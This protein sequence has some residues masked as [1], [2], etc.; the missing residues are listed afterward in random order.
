MSELATRTQL[1]LK[2][3]V[4]HL[5]DVNKREEVHLRDKIV[6][7]D[8][9]LMKIFP[10]AKIEKEL[11]VEGTFCDYVLQIPTKD[12]KQVF[13][14][15]PLTKEQ[16]QLE[17]QQLLLE[18]Q[19]PPHYCSVTQE[20][21]LKTLFKLKLW[22]DLGHRTGFLTAAELAATAR[23]G[24]DTTAKIRTLLQTRA[25]WSWTKGPHAYRLDV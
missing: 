21:D 9:E 18:I 4:E 13:S 22:Q 10:G 14:T 6:I 1:T 8:E 25:G 16:E 24:V 15:V 19:G 3:N 5:T 17:Y 2:E 7:V 12:F 23:V 20:L 11:P